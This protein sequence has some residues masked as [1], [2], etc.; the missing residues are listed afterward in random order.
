MSETS[1]IRLESSAGSQA[2]PLSQL[3]SPLPTVRI[4]SITRSVGITT[5]VPVTVIVFVAGSYVT[6]TSHSSTTLNVKL[7]LYSGPIPIQFCASPIFSTTLSC[8]LSAG[9]TLLNTFENVPS[10]LSVITFSAEVSGLGSQVVTQ[11]SGTPAT[12]YTAS[13]T[14]A[15]VSGSV[16]SGSVSGT[17]VSGSV[18]TVVASVTGSVSTGF[19]AVGS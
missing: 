8:K 15:V 9:A 13:P 10:P 6:V 18:A 1:V 2:T 19:V 16:V 12:T 17:V 4:D 3:P 7:S 14:G 5:P 11:S